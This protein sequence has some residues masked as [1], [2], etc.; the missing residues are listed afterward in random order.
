MGATV[1]LFRKAMAA[2][3]CVARSCVLVGAM[4]ADVDLLK[5]KQ[6]LHKQQPAPSVHVMPVEF[7]GMPGNTGGLVMHYIRDDAPSTTKHMW[8]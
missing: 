4:G 8:A 1:I 7:C 6:L 3:P 5:Q 2:R